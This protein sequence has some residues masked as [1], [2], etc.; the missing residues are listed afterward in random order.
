[1]LE[2]EGFSDLVITDNERL[3]IGHEFDKSCINNGLKHIG[4][5]TTFRSKIIFNV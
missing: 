4:T 3:F 5:A 1:M 2:T